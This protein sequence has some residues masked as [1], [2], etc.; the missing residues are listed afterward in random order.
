MQGETHEPSL[1]AL[2]TFVARD[3]VTGKAMAINSLQPATG[4]DRAHFAERQEI[5]QQRRA[6]R[7]AAS[8]ALPAGMALPQVHAWNVFIRP[9]NHH[10]RSV[11]ACVQWLL[12]LGLAS[13]ALIV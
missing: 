12:S 3:P 13:L 6:A 1:V 9:W 2:F 7:K 11:A 4:S 10:F 5:A 8:A